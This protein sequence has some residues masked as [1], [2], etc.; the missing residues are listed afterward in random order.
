LQRVGGEL[1][2]RQTKTYASDAEL[3]LPDICIRAFEH[4][5][6]VEAEL[7]EKATVWHDSGLVVTSAIARRSIRETSTGRSSSKRGRLGCR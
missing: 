6:R 1:V 2:H 3:P 5:Q 4:P 7:K